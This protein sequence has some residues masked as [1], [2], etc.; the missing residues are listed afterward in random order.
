MRVRLTRVYACHFLISVICCHVA[1]VV[2][3]FR[4]RETQIAPVGGIARFFQ[5]LQNV[6][7]WL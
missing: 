6:I 4:R 7:D 2:S 1:Q 5:Q 3:D